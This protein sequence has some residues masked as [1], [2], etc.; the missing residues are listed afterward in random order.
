MLF[1]IEGPCRVSLPPEHLQ[2]W[3]SEMASQIT[4]LS[5]DDST[6]AGRKIT[7]IIQALE[8]VGGGVCLPYCELVVESL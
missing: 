2:A 5:Y 6:S 8:E 3:F 7:Q 4:A 1:L